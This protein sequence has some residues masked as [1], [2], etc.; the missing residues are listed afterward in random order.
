MKIIF[1][2]SLKMLLTVLNKE[3]RAK[4]SHDQIKFLKE[5]STAKIE[6]VNEFVLEMSSF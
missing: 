4:L 2:Q 3:K 6:Y 1:K 5:L